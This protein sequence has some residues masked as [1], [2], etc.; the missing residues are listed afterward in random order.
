MNVHGHK[1]GAK[2][3]LR[4]ERYWDKKLVSLRNKRF[5]DKEELK[6]AEINLESWVAIGRWHRLRVRELQRANS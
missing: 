6:E 5:V 2:I 4:T 1:S 3:A